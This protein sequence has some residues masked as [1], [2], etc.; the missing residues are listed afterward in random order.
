MA[1]MEPEAV[2]EKFFSLLRS[3]SRGEE[4]PQNLGLYIDEIESFC[5]D[6]GIALSEFLED[7]F[8]DVICEEVHQIINDSDWR[9]D[10]VG[11][12]CVVDAEVLRE[13][14]PVLVKIEENIELVFATNPNTPVDILQELAE[15]TYDWEEDGTASTLARNTTNEHLLRKLAANSDPSTRYSVA[16]NP[17]TPEDILQ[18]LST[19]EQFSEHMMYVTFD[20]G[21]SPFATDPAEEMVKCSIKF[22]VVHN[23]N[24]P[25]KTIS[26]IASNE[27]NF[28]E[29]NLQSFDTEGAGVNLILKREAEKVLETRG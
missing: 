13:L 3:I 4:P 15:S 28:K 21:M 29:T 2:E 10:E 22:A 18:L 26:Q 5:E 17:R 12:K 6:D 11:K 27:K 19:D 1:A 8:M 23:P 24:T 25:L 7:V 20:G 9:S 14:Y 16:G